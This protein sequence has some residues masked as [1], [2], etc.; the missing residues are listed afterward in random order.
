M[1]DRLD[2]LLADETT[3]AFFEA[4]RDIFA[5]RTRDAIAAGLDAVRGELAHLAAAHFSGDEERAFQTFA[6]EVGL[7]A[8][9]EPQRAAA[10]PAEW[11]A[12]DDAAFRAFAHDTGI[13]AVP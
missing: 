6:E 5:R 4:N 1:S 3:R 9:P 7:P 13:R 12:A 2:E 10:V 8:L 11:S